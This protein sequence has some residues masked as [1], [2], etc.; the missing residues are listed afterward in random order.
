MNAKTTDP[1]KPKRRRTASE[2]KQKSESFYSRLDIA[3]ILGSGPSMVIGLE[4][5]GLLTPHKFGSRFV[6]YPRAEVDRL[7]EEARAK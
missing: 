4:K 1:N 5:A 6:R 7:I 2:K 3:R